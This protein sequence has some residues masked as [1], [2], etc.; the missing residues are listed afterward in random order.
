[1]STSR[2]NAEGEFKVQPD[3]LVKRQEDGAVALIIYVNGK[4]LPA[5]IVQDQ[6]W[7]EATAAVTP[8]AKDLSL[9]DWQLRVHAAGHLFE[10]RAGARRPPTNEE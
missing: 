5:I 7:V 3:L 9:M 10:A 1:M 8:E 2:F 6:D 4:R